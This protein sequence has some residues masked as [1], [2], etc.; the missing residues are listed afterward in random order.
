MKKPHAPAVRALLRAHPEGLTNQ[1]IRKTLDLMSVKQATMLRVLES[2]PDTYIDRWVLLR[3]SRGQ[4]SAIWCIVI[5]PED[6]P[7]PTDRPD[8]A[9]PKT[10]WIEG[11]AHENTY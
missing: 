11:E 4:Y 3:G 9:A 10:K 7:Y 2:M 1:E 6:C 5:P 8:R